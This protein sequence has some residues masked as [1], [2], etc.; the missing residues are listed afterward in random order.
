M[1]AEDCLIYCVGNNWNLMR[2]NIENGL[3]NFHDWCERNMLKL[4]IK[5]SKSL[6]I[7]S[8]HK[9]RS[10]DFTDKFK[11]AGQELDFVHT[12]NYLGIHLEK[13]MNL[14]PLLS[15]LKSRIVNKIYSLVKIRNMINTHC[16]ITI[17][18]QTILPI[19]DYAG[20]LLTSCNI[21]DRADLQK[22]QNHPLR[23]CFNVRLRDRVSILQ[24]H[25]RAIL[26]SLEQRRKKQLLWVTLQKCPPPPKEM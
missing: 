10:F 9:I 12:Y 16:A 7:G 4:N 23:I 3:Q 8:Y 11:L 2:P 21:S 5:K 25:T 1:Y 20:F 26:L 18:K 22:L 13:D 15:R 17:Y 24:M 19:F 6:L 14:I